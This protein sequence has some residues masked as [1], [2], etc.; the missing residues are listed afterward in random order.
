M[1]RYESQH[2][3]V[4]FAFIKHTWCKW[5]HIWYLL[6]FRLVWRPN[7]SHVGIKQLRLDSASSILLTPLPVYHENLST[8][9]LLQCVQT[10]RVIQK[11]SFLQSASWLQL[12]VVVVLPARA[13]WR[14]EWEHWY[15]SLSG[16]IPTGHGYVGK[17]VSWGFHRCAKC[18]QRKLVQVKCLTAFRYL[19]VPKAELISWLG[20][21]ADVLSQRHVLKTR[22]LQHF[23]CNN[24]SLLHFW[25]IYRGCIK[26]TRCRIYVMAASANTPE[27]A[28][29]M[30]APKP[31]CRE[32]ACSS[33]LRMWSVLRQ[34]E[35]LMIPQ[36]D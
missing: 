11:R 26:E 20:L 9:T 30:L 4:L 8:D 14:C 21:Q 33:G 6:I 2:C 15:L 16:C 12:H 32:V 19:W 36:P 7:H 5:G 31:S 23:Y 29:P 18:A 17:H 35:E 27:L 34:V 22:I 10:K 24:C 13:V 28:S 25:L 3:T 1:V